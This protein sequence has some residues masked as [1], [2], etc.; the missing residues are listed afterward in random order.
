MKNIL[1]LILIVLSLNNYSQVPTNGLIAYYPFNDN[2]NDLSGNNLHG[3]N[4]GATLTTDRFG[5]PYSAFYF[6]GTNAYVDLGT[7]KILNPANITVCCWFNTSYKTSNVMQLL[8]WRNY[9]YSLSIFG[10]SMYPSGLL[11]SYYN[12]SYSNYIL[13]DASKI[14]YTDGQWHFAA[15]TYDSINAN[16]YI[17]NKLI[18]T[19][20]QYY[21]A[22]LFFNSGSMAIGRDGDYDGKYYIGKIDDIRIYNRSLNKNEISSLFYEW[23]QAGNKEFTN[24]SIKVFPNPTNN[25]FEIDLENKFYMIKNYKINIVNSSGQSVYKA[26]INKQRTL[27]NLSKW[28]TKGIYIINLKD[29][30]NA[31]VAI[32]KIILN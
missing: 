5:N 28:A 19:V 26:I 14:D 11:V 3:I 18:N 1:I 27:I 32:E 30:N 9:G 22:P 21:K 17:D 10:N 20:N 25:I 13:N 31:I 8:R 23:L 29:E 6:N 16:F 2:V 12:N 4:Y 7:N 24:K 15:F